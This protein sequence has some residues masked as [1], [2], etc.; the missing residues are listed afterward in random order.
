MLTL[1]NNVK[2][3]HEKCAVLFKIM[4]KKVHL[5]CL[6]VKT[7]TFE[8]ANK[9]MF[10]GKLEGPILTYTKLQPNFDNRPNF[11]IFMFE[12]NVKHYWKQVTCHPLSRIVFQPIRTLKI[13]NPVA[14]WP[15]NFF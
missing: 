2:C 12:L 7:F 11:H 3:E 8:Y 1:I 6:Y 13:E 4:L 5:V 14:Y 10:C 15:I 9:H